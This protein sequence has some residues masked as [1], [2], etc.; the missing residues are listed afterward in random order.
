M[1]SLVMAI[2]G[3]FDGKWAMEVWK[4]VSHP[5]ADDP[6]TGPM[7]LLHRPDPPNVR[8]YSDTAHNQEEHTMHELNT[9]VA[10]LLETCKNRDLFASEELWRK[11]TRGCVET[12]VSL[13]RCASAELGQFG[14][15]VQLLGDI[16]V[17]QKVREL[18]SK[19][20]DQMFVMRWTCLSLVAI[21]PVLASD[22]DLYDLAGWAISS[23]T[24]DQGHTGEN[25]TQTRTIKT[26][27]NALEELSD[28]LV[29]S[30]NVTE[31]EARK[32]LS[33]N[34]SLISTLRDIGEQYDDSADWWIQVVQRGVVKATHRITCQLPGIKFDDPATE[35]VHLSQPN[36]SYCDHH[37][38]QFMSPWHRL[39]RISEVAHTF[40]NIIEGQWNNVAFK[41]GIKDLQEVLSLVR[42]DPLRR[43]REVWRLQ[44]LHEGGGLGFTVELFFL[45]LR[46]LSYTSSSGQSHSALLIGTFRGITSDWRKYK[47]S[48]GTQKL[49]LD[50][51]V[52]DNGI[53]FDATNIYP[54]PIVDA[55]LKLLANVFE[56]QGGSHIDD[57]VKELTEKSNSPWV[58]STRREFYSKALRFI[59]LAGAQGSSS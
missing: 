45:A 41:E 3:S 18:S 43:K 33:N 27:Y 56:G 52:S 4:N 51:V 8:P 13:V 25:Q 47:K 19:G 28:T 38:F 9:R 44:D 46:Q 16:G 58:I 24:E 36:E 23:L 31:A 7:A 32:I 10:H 6:D 49:L 20:K 29:L 14:D 53:I 48:L 57:T 59:S 40:H 35:S 22:L 11:R 2:P 21:Q 50:W 26:F 34:K 1:E 37:K 54:G 42:D 12:T 55:F 17:D 30:G 15:I 5:P 39:K